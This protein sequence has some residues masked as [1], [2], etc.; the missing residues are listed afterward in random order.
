VKVISVWV[1]KGLL[2]RFEHLAEDLG[3]SRESLIERGLGA[4]LAA[5]GRS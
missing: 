1:E 2:A 4:V 3:V 5:R